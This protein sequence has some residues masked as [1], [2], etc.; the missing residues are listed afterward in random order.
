[1]KNAIYTRKSRKFVARALC[2]TFLV[3]L[4]RLQKL[5]LAVLLRHSYCVEE[6]E[7]ELMSAKEAKRFSSGSR[8]SRGALERAWLNARNFSSFAAGDSKN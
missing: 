1:M 2:V 4:K 5:T 7:E 6:E 8:C 3:S